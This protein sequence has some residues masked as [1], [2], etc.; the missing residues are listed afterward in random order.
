MATEL[1]L[2]NTLK[3]DGSTSMLDRSKLS[4]FIKYLYP[5]TNTLSDMF[6]WL[7]PLGKFKKA[8]TFCDPSLN[9]KNIYFNAF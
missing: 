1:P 3:S 8:N 6:L 5:I 4:I 2:E 7:V 9:K